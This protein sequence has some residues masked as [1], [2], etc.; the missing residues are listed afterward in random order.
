[1]KNRFVDIKFFAEFLDD[2]GRF[3]IQILGA[4]FESDIAPKIW[5]EKRLKSTEKS[6]ETFY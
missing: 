1:M 3:S 5:I 2:F 6:A 4:I